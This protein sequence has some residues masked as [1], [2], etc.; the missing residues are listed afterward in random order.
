VAVAVLR[1][2]DE[3]PPNGLN[4]NS[5][6]P[7]QMVKIGSQPSPAPLEKP[8]VPQRSLANG[9]ILTELTAIGPG[10]FIVQNNTDRDAVVKLVDEAARHSVVAVYLTSYSSA[11]IE[12][13]PEGSFVALCGQGVDWDDNAKVFTREKSFGKFD[14]DLNFVTKVERSEHQI[15]QRH[16]YITLEL[17]PSITGNITR[18]KISE[19]TFLE[20]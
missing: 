2:R 6:P 7:L 8:A 3:P 19:K 11:T 20:Y 15:I 9:T 17:A 4:K 18:S 16:Q 10:R 13:I 12:Q 5:T 14:Q 1:N